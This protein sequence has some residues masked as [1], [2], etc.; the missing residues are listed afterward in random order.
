MFHDFNDAELTLIEPL[1]TLRMLNY[2]AWIAKRWADPA[3]P[4]VLPWFN[5]ER[6]WFEHILEL[7]EQL[8]SLQ[9]RALTRNSINY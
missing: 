3:F 9:D 4:R 7:R 8:A 1:R 6:Y 5:T 2:A